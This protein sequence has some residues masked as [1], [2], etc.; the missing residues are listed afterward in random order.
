MPFADPERLRK[1][2]ADVANLDFREREQWAGDRPVNSRHGHDVIAAVKSRI[3]CIVSSGG[4][5]SHQRRSTVVVKVAI[6]RGGPASGTVHHG[7]GRSHGN[8]I[9]RVIN[10]YFRVQRFRDCVLLQKRQQSKGPADAD[11]GCRLAS[12]RK[13]SSVRFVIDE[14][15]PN[16]FKWFVHWVLL[17]ASRAAFMVGRSKATS[18]PMM[19][20]TTRSSTS[21]NA[22]R[23][24][25][26]LDRRGSPA[27]LICTGI[28]ERQQYIQSPPNSS[29][30]AFH[31]ATTAGASV[32]VNSA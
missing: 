30:P 11:L 2:I 14:R 6:C 31:Q 12:R 15:K 32:A 21:V 4:L 23:A 26:D 17:A 5:A 18:K 20:I 25:A 27:H 10:P 9:G 28:V 8:G 7:H 24:G 19:A 22:S 13:H 16:C 29:H 1:P 3:G